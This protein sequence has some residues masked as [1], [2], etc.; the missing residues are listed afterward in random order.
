[1]IVLLLAAVGA[2]TLAAVLGFLAG[3]AVE[4]VTGS[5]AAAGSTAFGVF[6]VLTVASVFLI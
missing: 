1:M 6:A 4:K 3:L 2:L 5:D